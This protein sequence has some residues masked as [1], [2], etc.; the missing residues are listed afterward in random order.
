MKKLIFIPAAVVMIALASC[1]SLMTTLDTV[2]SSASLTEKEVSDGLKEALITGARN[3]A[4][5]LGVTDGYYGDQVIRILLPE[6]AAVIVENISK[7]PGGEKLVQDVVL[8]INRAAE[9]A[10][11]D[12]AP[13]FVNSVTS[14][15]LKDAFGILNGQ[16]NAATSYLHNTTYDQLYALYTPKIETSIRKPLLGNVSTQ[17]TWDALTGQWN[18]FAVTLAGRIAGFKT[19]E[20]DLSSYLTHKALDGM[21][22]KV[23]E[24]EYKIRENVNARVTPLL[25]RVFGSLDK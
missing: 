25:K 3:A 24:E 6:E 11:R 8:S 15:T 5:R 14:M 10:A 23:A 13:I 16:D 2:V 7:I 18:K 17:D 1:A 20:T 4:N 12:V 22:V 19:V 21:F 9:D